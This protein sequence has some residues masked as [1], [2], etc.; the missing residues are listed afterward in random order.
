MAASLAASLA[1]S[2]DLSPGADGSLEAA[3]TT[4]TNFGNICYANCIFMLL[5]ALGIQLTFSC[6]PLQKLYTA[7]CVP[8]DKAESGRL[9][10]QMIAAVTAALPAIDVVEKAPFRSEVQDDFWRFCQCLGELTKCISN[11]GDTDT[12]RPILIRGLGEYVSEDHEL[13]GRIEHYGAHWSAYLGNAVSKYDLGVTGGVAYYVYVR[14]A[15]STA[16]PLTMEEA[17]RLSA[18]SAVEEAPP[19]ESDLAKAL[20]S[21]ASS[22]SMSM[23]EALR[24]SATGTAW[25]CGVCTFDNDGGRDSCGVCGAARP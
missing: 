14:E 20:R 19:Y 1:A 18:L 11:Y 22:A 15:G 12:A 10:V 2:A 25:T 5:R 4:S 17:L 13:A 24:L 16:A 7:L 6:P 8:V 23:E 21:S 9:V 3:L